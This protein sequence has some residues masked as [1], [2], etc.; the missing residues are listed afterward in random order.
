MCVNI[1]T[2]SL[3]QKKIV[4]AHP[5]FARCF[6]EQGGL[7]PK[8]LVC[9]SFIHLKTLLFFSSLTL[10]LILLNIGI[11]LDWWAQV[12]SVYFIALNEWHLFFLLTA[13]KSDE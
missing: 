13:T 3:I 11:K 2:E 12:C 6:P 8:E 10:N 9:T 7:C 5:L 4:T 1:I